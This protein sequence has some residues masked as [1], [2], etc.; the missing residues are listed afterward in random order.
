MR[1][2]F[3][4]CAVVVMACMLC[5]SCGAGFGAMRNLLEDF[6]S[7][8]SRRD[9]EA[10]QAAIKAGVNPKDA[11]E[12]IILTNPSP[13]EDDFFVPLVKALAKKGN[14]KGISLYANSGEEGRDPQGNY[15]LG[16]AVASN[17]V[18]EA[19]LDGG[20]GLTLTK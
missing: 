7:A 16:R 5:L 18:M 2:R 19:L 1:K 15:R 20:G 13:Q 3:W 10:A 17:K 11:V 6:R 9:S 14:F 12:R 8:I 4:V